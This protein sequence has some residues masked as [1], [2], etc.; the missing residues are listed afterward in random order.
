[1]RSLLPETRK[2]DSCLAALYYCRGVPDLELGVSWGGGKVASS[3]PASSLVLSADAVHVRP[4]RSSPPNPEHLPQLPYQQIRGSESPERCL[5]GERHMCVQ[6][7]SQ[8]RLGASSEKKNTEAASTLLS[9]SGRA[10]LE[11]RKCTW[12]SRHPAVKLSYIQ[13]FWPASLY[14]CSVCVLPKRAHYRC[15]EVGLTA[16]LHQTL[17]SDTLGA[18]LSLPHLLPLWNPRYSDLCLAPGLSKPGP[19]HRRDS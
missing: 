7:Q 15:S 16:S 6:P 18:F 14:R 3:V 10:S 13:D 9:P 11:Y 5:Q 4:T 2:G 17:R 8:A 19:C 12:R 1:M